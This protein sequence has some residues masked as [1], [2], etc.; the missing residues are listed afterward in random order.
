MLMSDAEFDAVSYLAS[1]GLR[2]R[3]ASGGREITYPC[4]FDCGESASSNKRKLYVSVAEG[5]YQCKVC[6]ASGGS[7]TLQQHF[8]DEPHAASSN[9]AFLRRRILDVAADLGASMLTQN[10]DAMLYLLTERGLSPETVLARKLGFIAGAWSLVGT[11][12]MEATAE[13]LKSTG[14]VYR[15]GP[16][17]GK[18]FFY[19]HLL[20]PYISRGHV[21]QMRGRAWGETKG[22]KYLTGPG[23]P[24]RVY[25]SDSLDGAEDVIICEGEFDAMLL[26][27]TLA[28]CPEARLRRI[29]VIA[30]P[31]TNAIPDDFDDLLSTAKRIF[32]GLDSDEPGKRAAEELKERIGSRARVLELPYEDGRKCDWT[33][34]LLPA[35]MEGKK[36]WKYDHPYAGHDWRDVHR[37]LSSAS[38]K[39]IYSVAESGE[40]FR[41]YRQVNAGIKTGY[42]ELDAIIH[43]GL[44]PGQVVIFLAKTGAGKTVL[45]CNLAYLMRKH[46]VLFVSLEMTREEIYDRLRRIYLFY[47]PEANDQ[48]VDEG[49]ANVYICDENRLGERDLANLVSEFTIEADGKPEVVFV[50]YLGYYARGAKGTSPYEKATNAV[51]QLKAEAKAGRFVVIAPSQVN[52]L[53]K[54]GKP[55]DLDDARDSGAVEETADFLL[56]LYRPDDAL[57]AESAIVNVPLSGRVMITLLKS[58]HG[59]KGRSIKLQ[60]DLLTLAVVAD[61]SPKAALARTH[62]AQ[63]QSSG[64][65][66]EIMRARETAPIQQSMEYRHD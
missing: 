12:P 11:L 34:Y 2:G 15:D 25:N 47:H 32:I 57:Q 20:I 37:L 30:V 55:I 39:R 64:L 66:W 51:M 16:R 48:A 28:A 10:D 43:P 35:A 54:E 50:D 26:A 3:P 46:R 45:L 40:A 58:R 19:R 29:A 44:L 6:G 8:G 21:I 31:G 27:Q 53:A 22:G 42:N 5:L 24:T 17:A 63:S 1:K 9:D 23:E 38:G 7:Y 49:L 62:T 65:T 18:D 61:T 33:E 56:A 4:F 41:A 59:G 13:Q 52:R 36:S 60:M 14:L